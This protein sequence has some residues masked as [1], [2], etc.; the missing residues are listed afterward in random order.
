MLH[1]S[2]WL[3]P[4]G[5]FRPRERR[6]RMSTSTRAGPSAS[7]S[8]ATGRRWMSCWRWCPGRT[9]PDDRGPGASAHRTAFRPRRAVRTARRGTRGTRR[10]PRQHRD[11]QG[12]R[13]RARLRGHRRPTVPGHRRHLRTVT[14]RRTSCRR[15]G[16]ALF[17]PSPAARRRSARSSVASGCPCVPRLRPR[18]L[19]Y[20]K[21]T[22]LFLTATTGTGRAR[23][24]LKIAGMAAEDAV[25]RR[26]HR[27]PTG[28]GPR[29]H[30]RHRG[31]L[32]RRVGP[33]DRR[34]GVTAE[35][36]CRSRGSCGRWWRG[37][38]RALGRLC[39][40]CLWHQSGCAR[41]HRVR[42]SPGC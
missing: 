21:G 28:S 34:R 16:P 6:P 4:A 5:T 24:A 37:R 14:S 38:L 11:R 2:T 30:H 33:L 25:L 32:P 41:S 19:G 42:G 13:R 36:R 8:A 39:S 29:A 10:T 12:G 7:T 18:L 35:G 1:S 3:R 23:A 26:P 31:G 40:C 20:H 27:G 22:Y 17:A 15:S 9:V